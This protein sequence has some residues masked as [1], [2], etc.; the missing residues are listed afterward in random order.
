M[1]SKYQFSNIEKPKRG[2]NKPRRN[3]ATKRWGRFT[4]NSKLLQN[5]GLVIEKHKRGDDNPRGNKIGKGWRR[6]TW[7]VDVDL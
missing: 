4:R 7:I 6:L 2:D 3:K 1:T 5:T